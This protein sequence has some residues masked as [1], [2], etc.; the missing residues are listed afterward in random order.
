MA[1]V[2]WRWETSGSTAKSFDERK[3]LAC[4]T[5]KSRTV[6]DGCGLS[7]GAGAGAAAHLRS[8]ELR[9]QG[10]CSVR[11]VHCAIKSVM[12]TWLHK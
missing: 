3:F 6:I 1:G 10:K 12:L 8:V 7:T 11:T 9:W 5:N 2:R 4:N